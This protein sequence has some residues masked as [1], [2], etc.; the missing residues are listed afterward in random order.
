[1][2]KIALLLFLAVFSITA[3]FG[4]LSDSYR[5]AQQIAGFVDDI[6]FLYISS[7]AYDSITGNGFVG[8]NLDYTDTSND[9]RGIIA[10]TTGAPFTIPG[11]VIGNF[12][13]LSTFIESSHQTPPVVPAVSLTITHEKLKHTTDQN[14]Q[15]EYELSVSYS[16]NGGT[17]QT[18]YCLSTASTDTNHNKIVINLTS[19]ISGNTNMVSIQNAN[20]YF[21]FA[22]VEQELS[23]IGQYESRITFTLEG[24]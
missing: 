10:P 16:I 6:S 5:R 11:I 12:T 9:I 18:K 15:L 20:I 8:I 19:G 13:V 1:M 21:R 14:A 24:R 2:K 7:Y 17:S 22:D 23:V 4:A 3:V